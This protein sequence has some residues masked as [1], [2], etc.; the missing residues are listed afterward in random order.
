[1]T[2]VTL[3]KNEYVT[4]QYI[5]GKAMLFHVCH[6][7]ISG[8]PLRDLL[9]TGLSALQEYGISKW[10]SDDRLNGPMT[11]EDYQWGREHITKAAPAYGWKYWALVIPQDLLATESMAPVLTEVWELGQLKA[12]VFADIE[13]AMIWLESIKD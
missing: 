1:M 4:L 11:H 2:N 7:P 5:P 12:E 3:V 8:Q 10:L 13:S 9:L 6:K